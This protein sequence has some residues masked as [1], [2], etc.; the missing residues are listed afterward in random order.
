MESDFWCRRDHLAYQDSYILHIVSSITLAA[1]RKSLVSLITGSHRM[2]RRGRVCWSLLYRPI[3]WKVDRKP[4]SSARVADAV[5]KLLTITGL[6]G[7]LHVEDL[8]EYDDE[9]AF[10]IRVKPRMRVQ[11]RHA[12]IILLTSCKDFFASLKSDPIT[13]DWLRCEM[14]FS[15]PD[16]RP[17][18]LSRKP[19]HSGSARVNK[20]LSSPSNL[21]PL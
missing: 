4:C 21:T 18:F 10:R 2:L 14:L 15:I 19:E 1:V 12:L 8:K 6:C 9:E 5:P 20:G 16:F 17:L 7:S 3:W 11:S 13:E